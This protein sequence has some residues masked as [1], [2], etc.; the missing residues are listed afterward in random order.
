MVGIG[1]AILSLIG[2]PDPREQLVR[3]AFGG[4][5][6]ATPAGAGGQQP[7][8]PEAYQSPQELADLMSAMI[9]RQA[10]AQGI[11]AGI[12]NI[13]AGFS[14]PEH[15]ADT[16]AAF[17]VGGG[18]GAA[19]AGGAADGFGANSLF[20]QVLK[21]R[22]Q[23]RA[24]DQAQRTR[25]AIL[26]DIP[27]IA[28]STGVPEAVLRAQFETN[29]E[30]FQ[31]WVADN[32]GRRVIANDQRVVGMGGGVTVAPQF[33]PQAVAA[34]S[35][36]VDPNTGAV[37]HQQPAKVDEPAAVAAARA[38]GLDP[39]SP[40][41]RAFI[42]RSMSPSSVTVNNAG[43]N[44][45]ARGLGEGAARQFNTLSDNGVQAR[46]NLAQLGQLETVLEKAPSGFEAAF[47]STLGNWG[48]K[49]EGLD[50]I[51]AADA[52]LN[53]MIPAQR[54][55]GSGTMSDRD[56]EM[57][58]ASL[59]RL[60]NQPGG[61]ALILQIMRGM[62]EYDIALGEIAERVILGEIDQK[63]A[64]RLMREVANPIDALRAKLKDFPAGG[65]RGDAAA[66]AAPARGGP[67]SPPMAADYPENAAPA[68]GAGKRLR[69][70]PATGTL[71]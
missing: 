8:Q 55:A 1:D 25:A 54:P 27:T 52:M 18:G 49:T 22:E 6:T 48:I 12:G 31:K 62:Q 34:G 3:Q 33:A 26:A 43:E 23:Q 51:Q 65:G 35:G 4:A 19:G 53:Q 68:G 64:R 70:N 66:P 5:P 24:F 42:Q 41:G 36:L 7:A 71:E 17:G 13:A 44:A 45:L 60:I 38:Q 20:G 58:R 16:L 9:K 40:E 39:T 28:A 50:Q 15:R 47:K 37:I 59:P 57:F 10:Q 30:G 32:T 2:Q 61:N 14:R 56:V 69:F 11:T 29:P 67:P 63:E 46:R 21:V